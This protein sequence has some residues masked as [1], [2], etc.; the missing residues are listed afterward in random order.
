M[1][2]SLIVALAAA[3][4]LASACGSEDDPAAEPEP[5]VV[6]STTAD[7]V[8]ESSDEPTVEDEPT[9]APAATATPEPTGAE[10]LLPAE[11][12]NRED[13]GA[14]IGAPG[15]RAALPDGYTE[16]EYVFAGT[17][18]SYEAEGALG[19]DGVW[20]VT[21]GDA[22]DYRTRMIVRLP[23][24]DAFSGVVLVEWFNVTSGADISPDWGFLSEEIGRA[25]HAWVG[26]S[27]QAVG[28]NGQEGEFV[29]GG[30]IDV[31][32][33]KV[34]DPERYGDLDHPGDAYSF[35]IFTQAGAAVLADPAVLGGL[36]PEAVIALGESQ[37]AIFMTTYVNAVHPVAGLYDGFLVHSRGGSAPLPSGERGGELAGDVT[38]RTDLDEPVL[39]YVTETDLFGLGYVGARQDDTDTVRTWEVAGTAH[40][41]TYSI[42]SAAGLARDAGL[43]AI[44]GCETL[45]NDGPQ[46]ETLQAGVSHLVA[47]VQDGTLPPTSP[48]LTLEGD[49]FV[50]D[51]LGIATGGIRTPV[52]D[53]PNRVLSGEPGPDG[54]ACFLFGQTLPIEPEVLIEQHGT[55]DAYLDAFQASAD[56]AVAAGWLLEADAESMIAE[57]TERATELFGS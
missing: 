55:L 21:E 57:E 43:G 35:D 44:I 38:I 5:S 50:R 37:S 45:I 51:E 4:L 23:P 20:D 24:P 25:G 10:L 17:A 6:E 39:I 8:D 18:M 16:T 54:G 33:L 15:A 13:L 32:G 7:T 28:I 14:G 29:G 49:T 52:V 27:A 22:A 48:R 1:R 9:A 41:D 19:S 42:S 30:L 31:R 36:S 40:A 26:V 46:H 2:R 34:I 47:W 12:E 11:I 3:A 56:D 53:V